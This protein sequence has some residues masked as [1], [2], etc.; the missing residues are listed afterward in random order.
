MK[1][2]ISVSNALKNY[3]SSVPLVKSLEANYRLQ[4]NEKLPVN[5]EENSIILNNFYNTTFSD[6]LL[7]NFNVKSYDLVSLGS[8]SQGFVCGFTC[9]NPAVGFDNLE[10]NVVRIN[11]KYFGPTF[12]DNIAVKIQ[13]IRSK[14]SEYE[15]RILQE[16]FLMH[17]LNNLNTN[18]NGLISIVQKSIPR[19]YYGCTIKFQKIFFRLTFIDWINSEYVTIEK[20]LK[21]YT[22]IPITDEFYNNINK[23]VKSLWKLKITHNDLSVRNILVNITSQNYGDIKLIDFGLSKTL[24][25]NDNINSNEKYIQYFKSKNEHGSNI[26]KLKELYNS[27]RPRNEFN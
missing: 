14:A 11:G 20:Y 12:P 3:L 18:T 6:I 21:D 19:L 17:Y 27:L 8:G 24:N 10:K 26:E 16:E 7:K 23:I 13:I 15:K 2:N 5:L 22:H 4:K 25:T 1:R 9:K